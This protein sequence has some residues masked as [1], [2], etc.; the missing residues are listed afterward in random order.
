MGSIDARSF[1]AGSATALVRDHRVES[2]DPPPN[3][4]YAGKLEPGLE[5]FR[6]GGDEWRSADGDAEID[7]AL[8]IFKQTAGGGWYEPA[9]Q[10]PE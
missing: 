6:S 9:W 8:S 1:T 10:C 2:H 5:S 3:I 7:A 4:P